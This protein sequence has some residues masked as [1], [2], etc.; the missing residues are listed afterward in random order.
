MITFK[1]R[2]MEA[3]ESQIIRDID[4]D[5]RWKIDS[6]EFNTGAMMKV[7]VKSNVKPD[8]F[9]ITN[10]FTIRLQHK[11]AG[12]KLDLYA[13]NIIYLD[14]NTR[15]FKRQSI[16]YYTM[17]ST[18]MFDITEDTRF[19]DHLKMS[20]TNKSLNPLFPYDFIK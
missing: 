7:M 4:V 11:L 6:C 14:A 10:Q 15:A 16:R 20:L 9:A 12:R 1:H 8:E 3:P 13:A 2:S 17:Y 18:K 19:L 5:E